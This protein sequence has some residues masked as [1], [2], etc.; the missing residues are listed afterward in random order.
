MD[1]FNVLNSQRPTEMYEQRD[2]SRGTT[3]SGAGNELNYNYRSPTAFQ[4]PR[5]V[6]LSV[7]Y[8]F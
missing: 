2:F 7:R 6:R 4:E 3:G 5:Y 1:I 8:S